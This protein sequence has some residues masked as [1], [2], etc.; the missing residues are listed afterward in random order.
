MGSM[1][2]LRINTQ[3]RAICLG[4]ARANPRHGKLWK[5]GELT[6]TFR[7]PFDLLAEKIVV[8]RSGYPEPAESTAVFENW[9]PGPDSNQRPSG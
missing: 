6:A 2:G 4:D 3:A 8:S 9:L 5:D 1:T 7:Q